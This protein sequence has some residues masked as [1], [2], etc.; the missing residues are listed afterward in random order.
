MNALG[1]AAQHGELPFTSDDPWQIALLSREAFASMS[2]HETLSDA[3]LRYLCTFGLLSPSTH[4]TVPQ[5]FVLRPALNQIDVWVDRERVL[6]ESDACGRQAL[7]SVGCAVANIELAALSLGLEPRLTFLAPGEVKPLPPGSAPSHRYAPVLALCFTRNPSSEQADWLGLM[8]ERKVVRAEYDRGVELANAV[9][10]NLEARVSAT[11]NALRLHVL[12]GL[13]VLRGMGKFQE[14][15]DRFVFENRRFARE[16]G[17]WLLPTQQTASKIG[18]RGVEFGFDERFSA[19][20]H[21]S[22]R[23]EAPLLPD[24][25]A[26]FAKGGRLG[27][28]SSA[29]A[30]VITTMKDGFQERIHAGRAAQFIS[31]ELLRGGFHVAF[32]AALSEVDWAAAMFSATVLRSTRRPLVILRTGKVKRVE[33]LLRPHALRPPL[34]EV[35]LERHD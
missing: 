6:P 4:N 34:H 1:A 21:A 23:G 31:L 7:I 30:L 25:L 26:G 16:L 35:L 24:Q 20:V 13:V 3:Q 8:R 15:A 10:T 28:E 12:K 11:S 22:L 18:M 14:Q 5:R 33:D 32:H 29:A 17:D 9:A 27:L 19:E 2:S